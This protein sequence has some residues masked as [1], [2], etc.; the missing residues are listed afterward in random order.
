MK[1]QQIINIVNDVLSS[2]EQIINNMCL[3][4]REDYD[5]IIDK[6]DRMY[7]LMPGMTS[8]ERAELHRNM[9]KVFDKCILPRMQFR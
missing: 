2:R 8:D 4:F 7:T 3:T 1:K 6:D 5:T 9:R